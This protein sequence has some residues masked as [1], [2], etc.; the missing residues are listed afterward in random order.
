LKNSTNEISFGGLLANVDR[1]RKP[2]INGITVLLDTGLGPNRIDDLAAVAAGFCDRA[3]I[4]WGS[5]LITDGL[6]D[7]LAR[8]RTHGIEPLLGGTVFEY[9]YVWGKLD[10][11]LSI[12]R[13]SGCAIEVSDGVADIPRREKL[14]WI[15]ALA[16]HTQVFSELGGKLSAHQLDWP[17][18][19][20]EDLAAGARYV[21]IEGREIGPVGREI[22]SDLVDLVLSAADP[23]VIVF[24]ALERYQQIWFIDRLGPNV[25]LG[26]IKADDLV[27]LECFRQGL[28]EQTLLPTRRKFG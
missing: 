11:L 17:T 14:R 28:K 10:A 26:N 24:E 7:K 22:R 5:A 23:A 27:A 13:E 8:Y 6:G 19:I 12:V 9:A 18:C 20:R 21:V 15:E 4:A 1:T 2:R 16:A 3:K 25:N